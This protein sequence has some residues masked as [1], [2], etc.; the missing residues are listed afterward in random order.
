MPIF[1]KYKAIHL[2]IPKTAGTT[3]SSSLGLDKDRIHP[4][5][6][7]QQRHWFWGGNRQLFEKYG[8]P[9][10]H[11]NAA[12]VKEELGEEIYNEYFKFAFVRNPWDRLLSEFF[13]A[14]KNT[15][16]FY[17]GSNQK[18]ETMVRDLENGDVDKYE[19]R[20]KTQHSFL[21]NNQGKIDVDFLG[22]FENLKE[23]WVHLSDELGFPMLHSPDVFSNGTMGFLYNNSDRVTYVQVDEEEIVE[24]SVGGEAPAFIWRNF[25][26]KEDG[27]SFVFKAAFKRSNL[28]NG[29]PDL[30]N[31]IPMEF[32]RK[33]KGMNIKYYQ[34]I[35]DI[36]SQNRRRKGYMDQFFNFDFGFADVEKH[37]EE[38]ALD[39]ESCISDHKRGK[40]G[41]LVIDAVKIFDSK[42]GDYKEHYNNWS[43]EVVAKYYEEDIDTFKYTF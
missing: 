17:A 19:K 29:H 33:S 22:R 8:V 23:D 2:H 13:W 14:K 11:L 16:E 37:R 15:S 10:H 9:Y 7:A 20:L 27:D 39:L 21:K 40:A 38:E 35:W 36:K 43:K 30:V 42:K 6:R 32:L 3:I 34:N 1:H 25:I 24:V 41:A 31:S 4:Q 5:H 12:Q 26:Q 18:F 28:E